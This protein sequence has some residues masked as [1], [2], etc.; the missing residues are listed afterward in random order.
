MAYDL[1]QPFRLADRWLALT[2]TQRA[3][4]R[5]LYRTTRAAHWR[6][7][8]GRALARDLAGGLAA[9]FDTATRSRAA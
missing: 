2:R 9:R 4:V 3:L 1:A 7:L 8:G 5:R 6:Q